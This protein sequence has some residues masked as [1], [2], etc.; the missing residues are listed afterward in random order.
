[1][2]EHVSGWQYAVL[3][4]GCTLP[5]VA[6]RAC[7]RDDIAS[8]P[9][10]AWDGSG[11]LVAW[12]T[13]DG[14]DEVI[15]TH[16]FAMPPARPTSSAGHVVVRDPEI[17]SRPLVVAG[18]DGALLVYTEG[19][20][21]DDDPDNDRSAPPRWLA[22]ASLD[23]DGNLAA[24]PR[25]IGDHLADGTCGAPVWN[26]EAFVIGYRQNR[27]SFGVA[28]V[29]LAFVDQRGVT[30]AD[31][32]V[33]SQQV[34]WCALAARDDVLAVAF[35]AWD[36]PHH[37]HIGIDFVSAKTGVRIGTTLWLPNPFASGYRGLVAA[38]DGWAVLYARSDGIGRVV[39]FDRVGVH[40][41]I[42][43]PRDVDISTMSLGANDRGL[44]VA[45][46]DGGSVHARSLERDGVDARG[47]A[48][49]AG[50][51]QTIG[52]GATCAVAWLG[53]GSRRTFLLKLDGC[54]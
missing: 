22:G 32:N 16:R 26:G 3:A 37:N 48:P 17:R 14:R 13:F 4:A 52:H 27:G 45:W 21:P 54:P 1:M 23:R 24:S 30:R 25:R 19:P 44:F 12:D 34:T 36:E 28:S 5:L 51:T 49:S 38:K 42:E 31:T 43:L 41:S 20:D 8:A 2:I 11:Y 46:V 9:A 15:H 33:S 6:I 47:R 10:L 18:R 29:D 35:S 53:R 40:D 39:P 50:K 7:D